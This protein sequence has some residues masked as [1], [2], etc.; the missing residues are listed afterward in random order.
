M[1]AYLTKNLK[2]IALIITLLFLAWVMF[3]GCNT[4]PD[5]ADGKKTVDSVTAAYAV[6]KKEALAQ[7]DSLTRE[8]R[9]KDWIMDSL[10][11]KV[12]GVQQDMAVRRNA[13]TGTLARDQQARIDKDTAAIVSNCDTLARQVEAGMLIVGGYENLTDS[14][15]K[16]AK[17]Q[18][19]IKDSLAMAFMNLYRKSDAALGVVTK[20]YNVLYPDYVKAR[21]GL[22]FNK[23]LSRGLAV[24]LAAAAVK[25]FIIK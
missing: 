17:D 19:R 14:L 13:I 18:A 4:L 24:A 5:H 7:I 25:I 2:W 10:V 1:I 16:A 8:D 22:N 9:R 12:H 15:V 23:G 3:R 20:E 11:T 21:R 6:E